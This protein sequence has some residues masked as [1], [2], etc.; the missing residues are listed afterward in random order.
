MISKPLQLIALLNLNF[1]SNTLCLACGVFRTNSKAGRTVSGLPVTGESRSKVTEN[2]ESLL[3][4]TKMFGYQ[5]SNIFSTCVLHKLK[6]RLV[7]EGIRGTLQCVVVILYVVWQE[8]L[9]DYGNY[10]DGDCYFPSERG[11]QSTR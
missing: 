3:L 11:W 7:F 1:F 2:T 9:H 8:E 5:I 4:V 10:H 6:V